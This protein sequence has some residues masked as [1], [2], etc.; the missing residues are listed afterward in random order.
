MAEQ[1]KISYYQLE[2]GHEF[3]PKSYTLDGAAVESYLT[4]THETGDL[5]LKEGLVPPMA[6]TAFAMSAQSEGVDFPW[7]TVHVSQELEFLREARAGDTIT[8]RSKV[9]RKN[10]RGG[11]FIMSTDIEVLNQDQEVILTGKVGF[12]LPDPA[13]A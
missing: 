3:Q 5:F 10:Y 2:V 6:V 12:V 13:K 1:P 9:S 11:L 4:A 8:C 7:G